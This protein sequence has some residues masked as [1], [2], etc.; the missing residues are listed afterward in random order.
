[1]RSGKVANVSRTSWIASPMRT[2]PFW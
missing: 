2:V 1:S